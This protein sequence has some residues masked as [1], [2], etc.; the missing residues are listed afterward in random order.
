M[1]IEHDFD[2]A[3]DEEEHAIPNLALLVQKISRRQRLRLDAQDDFCQK[4]FAAV[5]E[6]WYCT[7][8]LSVRLTRR[9][10]CA[11]DMLKTHPL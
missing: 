1:L 8:A 6:K 7:V 2:A 5:L 4:L 3:L 10:D 9:T 11:S